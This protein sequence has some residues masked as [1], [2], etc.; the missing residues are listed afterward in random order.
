MSPARTLLATALLLSLAHRAPAQT[1]L[2][3]ATAQPEG[4]EV[5][6][7][8][9]GD[10]QKMYVTNRLVRGE[11]LQV[12]REQEDGWLAVVPPPG[13]FSWVNVRHL[14]RNGASNTWT[15]TAASDGRVPVL[16]GSAF[17]EGKPTVIGDRLERGAQVIGIG[18]PH[19]DEEGQWLPIVPPPHELRYVRKESVARTTAAAAATVKLTPP[20]R[21]A[22]TEPPPAPA[23]PPGAA[24][25]PRSPGYENDPLLKQARQ[26]EQARDWQEASRLY[27]QLG[28]RLANTDHDAAMQFHNYARWLRRGS[29]APAAVAPAPAPAAAASGERL[30]PVPAGSPVPPPAPCTPAVLRPPQAPVQQTGYA[31]GTAVSVRSSGPGRLR[32]T[33]RTID[34]RRAYYLES[35]QGLM[36]MYATEQAGV[37][38]EPL[39]DRNVELLGQVVPR[40]DV[41]PQYM[42]VVHARE[43][44]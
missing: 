25:P 1:V 18:Q 23:S 3:T 10:P 6:S 26:A 12:V 9:S 27:D 33:S 29:P 21:S 5:R 34:G 36:L 41:R 31:Q 2:Y 35:G 8:P 20:P 15:V 44:R 38:L 22:G 28:A 39:V 17:K 30:R 37:N 11:V 19:S 7:G 4:A 32:R 13:S 16:M 40:G 42:T 24:P 14:Q 43:L